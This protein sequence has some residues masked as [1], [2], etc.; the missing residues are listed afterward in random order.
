MHIFKTKIH[1]YVYV[2]IS[3]MLL[4]F[5]IILKLQKMFFLSIMALQND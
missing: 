1:T 5:S 4:M 3:K 2:P